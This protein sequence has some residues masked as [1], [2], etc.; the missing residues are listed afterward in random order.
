MSG[1]PLV[2]LPQAERDIGDAMEHYQREGG[3]TLAARWADAVEAA[4]RYIGEHPATGSARYAAQL[5]LA[6]LRFWPVR[7][8]PYLIFYVERAGCVDLW[9]I[10]HAKRNI[11]AW[12]RDEG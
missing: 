11:P 6:G 5:K 10:L 2:L 3:A 12:L 8:F 1:K 9:R 4:L 7:R